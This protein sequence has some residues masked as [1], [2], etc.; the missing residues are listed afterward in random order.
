VKGPPGRGTG[1]PRFFCENCGAEVGRDVK[2]CPRC[3]RY[4]G[5]VRCPS[6]DLVGAEGLFKDGCPICGYSAPPAAKSPR[7]PPEKDAPGALPLWAYILA[8]AILTGIFGFLFFTL[9]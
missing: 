9:L 8:G 6:C 5:S 4:F 3:G 1:D 2:H 7:P